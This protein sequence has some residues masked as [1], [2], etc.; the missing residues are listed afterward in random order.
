MNITV[1]GF[2]DCCFLI[3]LIKSSV[4]RGPVGSC[5]GAFLFRNKGTKNK[6]STSAK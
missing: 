5:G 1:K 4:E 2:R 6:E 3:I